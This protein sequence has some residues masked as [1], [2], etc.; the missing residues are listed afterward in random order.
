MN[1]DDDDD[2]DDVVYDDDDDDGV[3]VVALLSFSLIMRSDVLC[4][5]AITYDDIINYTHK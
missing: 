5:A 2:D 3:I 4:T 1:D